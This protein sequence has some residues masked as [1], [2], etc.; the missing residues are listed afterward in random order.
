MN[1][2]YADNTTYKLWSSFMPLLKS[3]SNRVGEDLFSIQQYDTLPDFS[4]FDSD[5]IFTKYAAVP[6]LNF[7]SIP[8]D[9]ESFTLESGTYAVFLHKGT[10]QNFMKTYNLIF[11]EWLPQSGYKIDHRPH[12]EILGG[13]YKNNHP[14]SEEEVWIP[15]L[16]PIT[17]T[18]CLNNP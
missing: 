9:M 10:P 11:R 12:F 2:S 16:T 3:I 5:Y 17:D 14:D 8:D 13:K 1:M 6:V 4:R 7:E 18:K 15:V